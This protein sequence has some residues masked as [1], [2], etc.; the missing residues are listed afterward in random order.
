VITGVVLAAGM[1]TRMGRPKLL[2]PLGGT[3][4]LQ[5]VLDAA[6]AAPLDEIVVVLGPQTADVADEVRLPEAG[7]LVM[8]AQAAEGQSTSLRCGLEAAVP[9]SE[10][11]VVLLGDQPEVRAD[12]VAAVVAAFRDTP[13]AVVQAAYSGV[14]AHPTVLAREVWPEV[15]A[16][17]RDEGARAWIRRH[18]GARR[19]VEVG[20]TPPADIDTRAD[21]ELVRERMERA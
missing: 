4:V 21:Y 14:P 2:L 17:G 18:P 8:N 12:A 13:A 19:L 16:G 9:E 10:A 7:R 11:A 3:V 15:V 1:S 5:H 20:G 6:A